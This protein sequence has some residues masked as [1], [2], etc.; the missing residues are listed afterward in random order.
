M[1]CAANSF[2]SI[3][4]SA[5]PAAREMEVGPDPAPGCLAATL[6]ML[7]TRP[8]PCLIMCGTAR[9]VQRIAP[10]TFNSKSAAHLASSVSRK[11]PRCEL[12]A[13][14]TRISMRPNL[15]ATALMNCSM[16]AALL[17]SA[18]I[19]KTSPPAA[20]ISATACLTFSASRL[21]IATL[22]PCCAK[23][24]AV[25]LPM[26][27]VLPVMIATLPLSPRSTAFLLFIILV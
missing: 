5:S 9:R 1:F 11:A 7:M 6:V 21:Q 18:A 15:A 12:P 14:L 25:A 20:S 19:P 17:I 16:S 24:S 23:F 27:S 22:A 2:D 26:P 13:L 8:P 10:K 3:L 4:V